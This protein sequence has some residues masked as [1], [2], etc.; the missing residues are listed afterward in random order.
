MHKSIGTKEF[1]SIKSSGYIHSNTKYH[2]CDIDDEYNT[3][4]ATLE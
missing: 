4:V 1:W 3:N 2:F